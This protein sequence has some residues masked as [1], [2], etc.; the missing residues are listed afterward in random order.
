[1]FWLLVLLH[2]SIALEVN[3]PE[4]SS[5]GEEGEQVPSSG[6]PSG[7]EEGE[8]VPSP[9]APSGGEEGEEEGEEGESY[10]SYGT[11]LPAWLTGAA[12]YDDDAFAPFGFSYGWE[13]PVAVGPPPTPPLPPRS[14]I[15][16]AT[17]LPPAA[18]GS[19]TPERAIREGDLIAF[20]CALM[21]AN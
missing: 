9:G 8:E 19:K 10:E 14:P 7:G 3:S 11:R 18:C 20:D 5:G 21:R 1:M 15:G 6:A 16:A 2:G 13:F 17:A 4:A 12:S